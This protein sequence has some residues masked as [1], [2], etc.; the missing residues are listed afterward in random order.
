MGIWHHRG[1]DGLECVERKARG[2]DA[3]VEVTDL[4]KR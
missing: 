1:F 3:R 2:K 4:W